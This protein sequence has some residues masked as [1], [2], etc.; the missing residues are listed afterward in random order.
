MKGKKLLNWTVSLRQL[1]LHLKCLFQKQ[2]LNQGL[3]FLKKV[4]K[5]EEKNCLSGQINTPVLSA[6]AIVG[7]RGF[8]SMVLI[9]GT[10]QGG[11]K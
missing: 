5:P 8:S 2:M 9:G 10:E 4:S 7:F 6:S 11:N 3:D 1:D